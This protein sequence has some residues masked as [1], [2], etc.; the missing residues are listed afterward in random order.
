M[1]RVEQNKL[2]DLFSKIS[3]TLTEFKV[4]LSEKGD[5]EL[6][7]MMNFFKE[8]GWIILEKTGLEI[9]SAA[10]GSG[11]SL[12]YKERAFFEVSSKLGQFASQILDFRSFGIEAEMQRSNH[13]KT[14]L[15]NS[16][17]AAERT[18]QSQETNLQRLRQIGDAGKQ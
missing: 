9:V 16:T 11:A 13:I 5:K 17:S 4:Q 3:H 12:W 10:I 7:K 2:E 1:S 18:I 15:N 6:E 14:E 8:K